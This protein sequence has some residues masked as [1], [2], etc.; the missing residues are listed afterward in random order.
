MLP[1]GCCPEK[2]QRASSRFLNIT[3]DTQHTTHNTPNTTNHTQHTRQHT[4]HQTQHT[5]RNAPHASRA[6]PCLVELSRA[7]RGEAWL[8][9]LAWPSRAKQGAAG[10]SKAQQGVAGRRRSYQGSPALIAGLELSTCQQDLAGL[11]IL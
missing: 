4:T 5:T 6:S 11:S 3:R 7:Y 9:G 10:F 2:P 1:T 8:A